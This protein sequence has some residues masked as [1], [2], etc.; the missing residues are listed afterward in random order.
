MYSSTKHRPSPGQVLITFILFFVFFSVLRKYFTC[1]SVLAF[2]SFLY[3]SQLFIFYLWLGCKF[4]VGK[5]H[6]FISENSHNSSKSTFEWIKITDSR[7]DSVLSFDIV[8][9]FLS[10]CSTRYLTW[11]KCLYLFG[12]AL[13]N[14]NDNM[15]FMYKSWEFTHFFLI[16]SLELK[17]ILVILEE[18]Q[19][20]TINP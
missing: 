5:K 4:L 18:I 14:Y 11:S 8:K 10:F 3:L 15:S 1:T 12:V 7:F 13:R 6:V 9:L 20:V 17:E 2:Y 16:L 19:V